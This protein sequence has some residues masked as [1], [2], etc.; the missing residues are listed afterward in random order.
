MFNPSLNASQNSSWSSSQS[1]TA[2]PSTVRR[3]VRAPSATPAPAPVSAAAPQL[4]LAPSLSRS[5]SR[6]SNRLRRSSTGTSFR[7]GQEDGEKDVDE[8]SAWVKDENYAVWEIAR[9]PLEL[10]RMLERSDP[11]ADAFAGGYRDGWTYLV[12]MEAVWIW[13]T[14]QHAGT[15]LYVFAAPPS[16]TSLY[17]NL[18]LVTL[19]PLSR[20]S[21]PSLILA[22]STTGTIHF[23][24]SLTHSLTSTPPVILQI[25]TFRSQEGEVLKGITRLDE[26][27]WVMYTSHSRLFRLDLAFGAAHGERFDLHVREMKGVSSGMFGAV[28]GSFFGRGTDPRGGVKAVAVWRAE[29]KMLIVNETYLEGWV[30]GK[31]GRE[32]MQTGH[33]L[34]K[35]LAEYLMR[36]I[37]LAE[38]EAQNSQVVDIA[39]VTAKQMVLLLEYRPSPGETNLLSYCLLLAK[40]PTH[41]NEPIHIDRLILLSHHASS[42]TTI[43]P[44]LHVNGQAG[45]IIFPT[46][47]ILVSLSQGADYEEIISLKKPQR[48]ILGSSAGFHQK[49]DAY[50]LA[51]VT[52]EYGVLSV[53]MEEK[54][55]RTGRRSGKMKT[56]LEHAMF[57]GDRPENPLDFSV[58]SNFD[59]E[60]EGPARQLSKDVL[61]NTSPKLLKVI[62]LRTQLAD[63]IQ[64]LDN[65]IQYINANGLLGKLSQTCRRQLSFNEEKLIAAQALWEKQNERLMSNEAETTIFDEAVYIHLSRSTGAEEDAIRPFLR[66]QV[67][68][69]GSVLEKIPEVLRM[70]TSDGMEEKSLTVH[71]ANFVV[72]TAYNSVLEQ[73]PFLHATY[74]IDS[75]ICSPE[76]WT[77]AGSLIDVVKHLFE[78]TEHA[79]LDHQREFGVGLSESQLDSLAFDQ[80]RADPRIF[81]THLKGQLA[82]L[83]N[84]YCASCE[85]R[86]VF[87]TTLTTAESPIMAKALSDRYL[88][89]R[90][91]MLKALMRASSFD[92]AMKL[93]QRYCDFRILVE[94]C[95]HPQY[96]SQDKIASMIELFKEDF[97]FQLYQYY[98]EQ[99]TVRRLLEQEAVYHNLLLKFLESTDN[100]KL[101][102]IHEVLLSRHA[103][104]H[105]QLVREAK[106]EKNVDEHKLMLSIAKLCKIAELTN[107]D[108]HIKE[109]EQVDQMLDVM[110][111]HE[112]I[113]DLI[114]RVADEQDD[115]V[116]TNEDELK[117]AVLE[118]LG[119]RLSRYKAYPSLFNHIIT[120]IMQ[121][122]AV[123]GEDI[124]DAFT[125][126][127]APESDDPD[128][129]HALGILEK[130]QADLPTARADFA[131]KTIWRRLYIAGDVWASLRN[132]S[133]SDDQIETVL[134]TTPLALTLVQFEEAGINSR[135]HLAPSDCLFSSSSER[136]VLE[137]RFS[138]LPPDMLQALIGDYE[139]ESRI[140][141]KEL[142]EGLEGYVDEIFRLQS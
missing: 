98:L 78:M 108:F 8:K 129:C 11:Y 70:R 1:R 100:P 38:A 97:A 17:P 26:L 137:A 49:D 132:R 128:F 62:D 86:L 42:V 56:K 45:C 142:D 21:P 15:T 120:E 141:Q 99:G 90:P 80:I 122:H 37:G 85:E 3:G 116:A 2:R 12:S 27:A 92:D 24:A 39:F 19:I 18:P 68:E 16:T 20:S 123:S 41:S 29:G 73:R 13:N 55:A 82:D 95:A 40:T 93:A 115:E 102:W 35:A 109:I 74:G 76:P 83:V 117:L 54:A 114:Q 30:V 48:G 87:L 125:L 140:L 58:L 60:I 103:H 127:E 107:A 43:S 84:V 81:Q 34:K 63:R 138:H 134:R 57:Y 89:T 4:A 69:I 121:H 10:Q 65:L 66:N 75:S 112:R 118:Q 25:P 94:L 36:N 77:S 9:L 96:G 61:M 6:S 111:S 72:L 28:F 110:E 101:A 47:L 133:I 91:L 71:E 7:Q 113:R 51:V 139:L 136:Q 53:K 88:G 50:E 67:N 33:V 126:L 32:S 22:S 130:I 64:K 119:A 59:E 135:F 104:A 5:F 105:S 106:Q 124:I 44:K 52:A 31:D 23:Y 46:I 14:S 131:L 79:L